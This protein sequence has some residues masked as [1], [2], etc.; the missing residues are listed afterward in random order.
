VPGG[1]L[2]S[3]QTLSELPATATVFRLRLYDRASSD[4]IRGAK[5]KLKP[6]FMLRDGG[7]I[8]RIQTAQTAEELLDLSPQATGL[9]QEA[10]HIRMRSFGLQAVPQIGDVLRQVQSL[11]DLQVRYRIS[12]LLITELRWQG[13]AGAQALIE[14]LED[15]PG[16]AASLACVALGLLHYPASAQAV[17]HK[18]VR[19]KAFPREAYFIGG[20][21]GLIDLQDPR[22][23]G[24][25]HD[26]LQRKNDYYELYGF[27]SLAG[28]E[29]AFATLITRAMDQGQNQG[30][31]ALMAA[32][33]IAHRVGKSALVQALL[34]CAEPDQGDV[35][36]KAQAEEIAGAI[37]SRP[38]REVQEYFA[39]FYR[40]FQPQ[41]AAAIE[42]A[43]A[44]TPF[45]H[46]NKG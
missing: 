12:A 30:A 16:E 34:A 31:D 1:K 43:A 24:E 15:L 39:L 5:E 13:E 36:A 11:E 35:S 26:D 38:E 19:L 45:I 10:W 17:W 2:R 4:L 28:D 23:A 25:L 18:Y 6:L 3:A 29:Q 33:A 41:D 32:T 9:A 40:G 8:R 44:A 14:C 21:W 20:L 7:N 37:L 27:L 42:A 46:Q 22:V